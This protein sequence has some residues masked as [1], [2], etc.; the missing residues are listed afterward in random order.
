MCNA[1]SQ[2]SRTFASPENRTPG[3]TD[4]R[5]VAP[6]RVAAHSSAFLSDPAACNAVATTD[7]EKLTLDRAID[8]LASALIP[9]PPTPTRSDP[10]TAGPSPASSPAHLPH[11]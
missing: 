1:P 7:A 2:R 11:E 4:P 8:T 9:T 5:A 6:A 10:A 3:S